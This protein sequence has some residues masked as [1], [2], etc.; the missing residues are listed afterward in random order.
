MVKIVDG[1][2][3]IGSVWKWYCV[4]CVIVCIWFQ[5]VAVF[6]S[7]DCCLISWIC[8]YQHPFHVYLYIEKEMK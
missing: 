7:I 6:R 1:C 3:Q 2:M 5:F 8:A 4:G